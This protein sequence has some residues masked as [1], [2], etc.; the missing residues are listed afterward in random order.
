MILF[1]CTGNVCRSPMAEYLLKQ[2]LGRGSPWKVESAGTSAAD[3]QVASAEACKALKAVG[4]DMSCH[5]SRMITP[6]IIGK[7]KLIVVMTSS[8]RDEVVSMEPGAREKV[9]LLKSFRSS[10]GGGDIIDPIGMSGAVY[11]QT[12]DEIDGH[13]PELI[14]F[15]KELDRE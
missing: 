2:R 8:H 10:G 3:G 9:F 11:R 7:A 13:L 15:M 1:V 5:T 6:E 4:A 14:R 12:R